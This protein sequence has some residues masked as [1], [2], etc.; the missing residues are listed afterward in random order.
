[1]SIAPYRQSVQDE[2]MTSALV[3]AAGNLLDDLVDRVLRNEERVATAAEGKLLIAADD[4]MEE[5]ADR[6]QRFVAV[7]TPTVRVLARGA[8]FTRV[9]WVLVAS[10]AVSL[11]TTVR[12]GVREVRVL[13][14]L[15]AFRLEQ[16]N[17]APADPAL[18]KKLAVELYL[19]PKRKPD[20]ARLD[21][22]LAKLARRWL[23]RGVFGR[24]TRR[25]AEKAL[26]AAEQLDLDHVLET[27]RTGN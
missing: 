4:G 13:G 2:I 1:M 12:A 9:P 20:V 17:G 27:R 6:V 18:V 26:D 24:D 19:A 5:V 15:L 8:R 22:P 25:A 23:L 3:R 16:V 11:T 14:S 21:L 7:A 10:T